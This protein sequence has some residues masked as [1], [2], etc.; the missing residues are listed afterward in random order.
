MIKMNQLTIYPS[1]LFTFNKEKNRFISEASDLRLRGSFL[2]KL[3]PDAC[4]CGFIIKSTK[5]GA[6]KIFLCTGED[7]GPK[8][9]PELQSWSFAEYDP[10]T[11]ENG[12]YSAII[13]ND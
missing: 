1:N 10:K 5:T 9:E 3:W 13:F 11:N 6:E 2:S 12:E 7:W 4:D 8:N